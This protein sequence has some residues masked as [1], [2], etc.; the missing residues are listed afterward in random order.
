MYIELEQN[1]LN[2][3][4]NFHYQKMILDKIFNG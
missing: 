2:D 3:L 1:V 4:F